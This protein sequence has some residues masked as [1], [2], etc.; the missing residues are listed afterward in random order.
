MQATAQHAKKIFC[1][2]LYKS[3]SETVR[4]L[5]EAYGMWAMKKTQVYRWHKHSRDGRASVN[6]DQRYGKPSASTNDENIELVRTVVR[7][8]Q[9]KNIQ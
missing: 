6:D 7:N 1:V 2:L 8:D 5:D 3:L 4:M 9:R